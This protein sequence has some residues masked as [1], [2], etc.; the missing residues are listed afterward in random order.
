MGRRTIRVISLPIFYVGED[1]MTY[2]IPDV[3]EA[4]TVTVATV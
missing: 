2:M 4:L 1:S 3:L